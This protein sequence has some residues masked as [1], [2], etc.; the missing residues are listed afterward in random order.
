MSR[1]AAQTVEGLD[2]KQ[3]LARGT[4]QAADAEDFVRGLTGKGDP[5]KAE[6]EAVAAKGRAAAASINPSELPAGPPGPIDFDAIL[7]GAAANASAPLGEGPLLVAFASLSMPEASLSRLIADT[8]RAG[9]IVV[10]RGMS[11]VVT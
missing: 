9:G 6:A 10:F 7:K 2:I 1:T 8:A 5:V 3:V 11:T 4:G